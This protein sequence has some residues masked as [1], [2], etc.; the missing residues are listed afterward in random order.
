MG[1]EPDLRAVQR[2]VEE[3]GLHQERVEETSRRPSLLVTTTLSW[4]GLALPVEERTIHTV[5]AVGGLFFVILRAR[6]ECIVRIVLVQFLLVVCELVAVLLTAEEQIAA[7]A[8]AAAAVW[9]AT[10]P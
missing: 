2:V 9:K 10:A 3:V 5:V 8:A 7:A 1:R 4:I 6:P